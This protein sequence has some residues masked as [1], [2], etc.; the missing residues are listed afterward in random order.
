MKKWG[1]LEDDTDDEIDDFQNDENIFKDEYNVFD[2]VGFPESDQQLNIFGYDN[3]S[4]KLE[5]MSRNDEES[6]KI[7]VNAISRKI[8]GSGNNI[9]NLNNNDIKIM[10]K[11]TSELNNI[12]HKNPNFYVLGYLASN[13]GNEIKKDILNKVINNVAKVINIQISGPSI[14]RYARFWIKKNNE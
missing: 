6:F 5:K 2:R 1:K 11:K 4:K 14:L 10:L 3:I 7:F 8:I 9:F 12:K 13:K